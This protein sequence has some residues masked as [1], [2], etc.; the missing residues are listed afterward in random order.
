MVIY[1]IALL[2]NIEK[3]RM[4]VVVAILNFS[5]S[6]YAKA[7]ET[8]QVWN[9]LPSLECLGQCLVHSFL[10]LLTTNTRCFRNLTEL[11]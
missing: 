10:G 2:D 5:P 6:C 7:L 3:A 4:Q 11:C 9:S 1:F 8:P